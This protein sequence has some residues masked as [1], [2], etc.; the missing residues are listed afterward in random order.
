[1]ACSSRGSS[2]G[3]RSSSSRSSGSRSSSGG[4]SSAGRSSR[5]PS[6]YSRSSSSHS[7]GPTNYG[8]G[9][10][11]FG[12]GYRRAPSYGYSRQTC[13]PLGYSTTIMVIIIL[14]LIFTAFSINLLSSNVNGIKNTT[15][16]EA[17]PMSMSKETSYYTDT[18]GWI[19]QPAKLEKG[20]REFYKETGVQ[21]H[22]YIVDNMYGNS[23]PNNQSAEK[24]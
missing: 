15:A 19:K 10:S 2:G 24:K 8:M 12:G 14:A 23:S 20:M 4:M 9:P 5:S 17:L 16:R 21:P 18:L 22:L 1:M 3:G 13:S 7:K 6:S 11:L